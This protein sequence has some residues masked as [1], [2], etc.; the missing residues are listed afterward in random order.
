MDEYSLSPHNPTPSKSWFR[1]SLLYEAKSFAE[2]KE[3]RIRGD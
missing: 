3:H 2:R 1:H